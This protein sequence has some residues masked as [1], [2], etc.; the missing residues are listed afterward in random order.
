VTEPLVD[1]LVALCRQFGIYERDAICCGDVTVSQCVALQHLLEGPSDVS[2]LAAHLGVT[3]SASTRLL[4]GMKSRGWIERQRD[5]EDGRRVQIVLTEG[6]DAEA[7]RLRDLTGLR[8]G[9][10]LARIP[11]EEHAVVL[12]ALRVLG[13]AIAGCADEEGAPDGCCKP[14]S[15]C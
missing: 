6:G 10:V 1:A 13:E 12:H 11:P 5:V 4:D 7:H 3:V 8:I 15:C 2:G 9:A 14:S